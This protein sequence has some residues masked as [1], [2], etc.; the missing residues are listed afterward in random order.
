VVVLGGFGEQ[1]RL[2]RYNKR[3]VKVASMLACSVLVL[4]LIFAL[5]AGVKY[6]EWD[7]LQEMSVAV[8]RAAAEPVR[9]RASLNAANDTITAVNAVIG[10]YP[11]PHAALAQLTKLLGDDVS[12]EYFSMTGREIKIRGLAANAAA[13]IQQLT[14][15]PSYASVL[16]PQAITSQGSAG[17][18]RFFLDISLASRSK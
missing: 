3:L 15:E 1:K 12:L 4:V 6:A 8:E 2:Q 14:E 9:M 18:E 17:L 5:A 7:D 11:G 16:A 13:V 10:E